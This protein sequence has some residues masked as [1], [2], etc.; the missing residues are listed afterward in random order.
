MADIEP[1]KT[2]ADRGW[3]IEVSS[4]EG[5]ILKREWKER[6]NVGKRN[7]LREREQRGLLRTKRLS[8]GLTAIE[9]SKLALV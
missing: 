3:G 9:M 1:F 5:W 8:V 2:T 6:K 7:R 4:D